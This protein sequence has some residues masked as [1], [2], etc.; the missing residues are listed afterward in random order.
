MSAALD[1][2]VSS[3]AMLGDE[4]ALTL[5]MM[6]RRLGAANDREALPPDFL[7][8]Q[9][10]LK[11]ARGTIERVAAALRAA[12]LTPANPQPQHP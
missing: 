5:T 1:R 6:L 12:R 4:T 10:D 11:S 9:A 8:H 7:D 2:A 3:V